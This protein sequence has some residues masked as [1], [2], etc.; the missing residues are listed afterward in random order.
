MIRALIPAAAVLALAGPAAAAPAGA[1]G[2]AAFEGVWSAVEG[3]LFDP[4][5]GLDGNAQGVRL[6]PPYK[7]ADEARYTAQIEANKTKQADPTATCLPSGVPRLW[8]VPFPFEIMVNPKR[9]TIIHEMESQVRRVFTDGRKHPD[10]LDPSFNGHSIGHWEG[11]TLVI[12]TVGLRA[13]TV[14][15]RTIAHHTARLHL[16][17]R[18]RLAKPDLLEVQMTMD[19]PDVFTR[20]WVVTRHYDRQP[21]W[22]LQEYV[23]L[24]NNRQ[25]LSGAAPK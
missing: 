7:P 12:D 1:S 10:A 16:T 24:E 20:P 18:L 21:D 9:V 4:S 19:D 8:A 14:Y 15:D 17:E 11:D 22:E 13:D 2:H 25:A 3:N 23:C 5:A 6:H